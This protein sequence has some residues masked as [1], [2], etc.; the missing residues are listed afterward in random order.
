M[1]VLDDTGHEE[2]QVDDKEHQQVDDEDV[3][4]S[5]VG[6]RELVRLQGREA[7]H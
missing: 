7:S 3:V 1:P 5:K 6:E 2:S 4:F